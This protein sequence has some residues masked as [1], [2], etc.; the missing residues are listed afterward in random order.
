MRKYRIVVPP[1]AQDLDHVDVIRVGGTVGFLA[2]MADG[3]WGGIVV[4]G[5]ARFAR[6][7]API[8]S[9]EANEEDGQEDQEDEEQWDA[10]GKSYDQ[11]G[12]VA[13][14]AVRCTVDALR[15]RRAAARSR[16]CC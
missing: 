9:S 6:A 10:D 5:S 16:G 8:A 15:C 14:S 2:S 13:G 4:V 3:S 7:R 1:H 12:L 11:A